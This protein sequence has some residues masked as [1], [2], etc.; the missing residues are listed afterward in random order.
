MKAILSS[1]GQL[2]VVAE[3]DLESYA[4]AK[5]LQDYERPE[6]DSVLCIH[7]INDNLIADNPNA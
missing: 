6:G 1:K 5:W 3:G 2:T 4:L 7:T